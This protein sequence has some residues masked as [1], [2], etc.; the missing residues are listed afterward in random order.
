MLKI[1]YY[2][3]NGGSVVAL[4]NADSVAHWLSQTMAVYG[5][6]TITRVDYID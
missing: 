1:E 2:K 5:R 3:P 4:I 6:I